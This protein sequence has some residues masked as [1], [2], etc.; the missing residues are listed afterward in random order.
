MKLTTEEAES[1]ALARLRLA[2][3]CLVA[4]RD[5]KPRLFQSHDYK[6]AFWGLSQLLLEI[7]AVQSL[8]K[9]IAPAE[10]DSASPLPSPYGVPPQKDVPLDAP[11]G[12]L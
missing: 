5:V 4:A 1:L 7:G 2:Y 6:T 3:E 9:T 10:D 8:D 12:P 11:S